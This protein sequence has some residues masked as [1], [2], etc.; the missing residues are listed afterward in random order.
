MKYKAVLFDLD[1]TL[2]DTIDDLADSMNNV[3]ADLN[4]PRHSV[5]AYKYFVGDGLEILVKR[6]LPENSSEDLLKKAYN[7]MREEYGRNWAN[8][9]K[10][11]D[12]ITDL[13]RLLSANDIKMTILTNKPD[14]TAQKVVSKFLAGYNFELVLGART[15]IPKKPNPEGALEIAER[16]G[17]EPSQFL[18]FGDTKTDMK[19]A[20]SAGMFPVGVLWGF[21][22]AD[23]LVESGAKVII[24]HPLNLKGFF[25]K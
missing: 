16:L 5:E 7:L 15:G 10:P 24:S 4:L 2:L 18:Y 19:T 22:K 21:R 13:L 17:I 20:Q 6:A 11:Y 14:D 1:G 12:G 23:E 9:T 8:K 25:D 3:L